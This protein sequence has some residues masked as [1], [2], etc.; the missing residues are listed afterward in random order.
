MKKTIFFMMIIGLMLSSCSNNMFSRLTVKDYIQSSPVAQNVPYNQR[1]MNIASSIN[2]FR[3]DRSNLDGQIDINLFKDEMLKM[4][5]DVRT[6]PQYCSSA[7]APLQWNNTLQKAAM[8]HSKDVAL[9]NMISHNGSGTSLD[10][11]SKDGIGS[12]FYER[13]TYFGYPVKTKM[14]LGEVLTR[15]NV[16]KTRS[17]KLYANFKRA[18]AKLLKDPPHCKIIMNPRFN[19][20][21]VG[22]YRVPNYYY[23]VLNF[24]QKPE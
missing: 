1:F 24:A 6:H 14:L 13:L 20:I 8:V 19:Y 11:A 17:K 21:A 7:Q 12:R 9:N 16:K 18:L 4:I 3:Y 23:F 15:T 2:Y 5:N 10:V 22:V